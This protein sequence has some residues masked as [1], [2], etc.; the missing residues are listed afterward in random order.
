M[1]R[2]S[3]GGPTSTPL[4]PLYYTRVYGRAR[5]SPP[6]ERRHQG[7][8]SVTIGPIDWWINDGV[9]VPTRQFNFRDLDTR[10]K[11]GLLMCVA[12]LTLVVGNPKFLGCLFL[13][14]VGAA[15][16]ARMSE[17][18]WITLLVLLLL[19]TWGLVW[20]QGLFYGSLPRTVV[21]QIL[22]PDLWPF[23]GRE[24]LV[25]YR[26]GLIHGLVQSLRLAVATVFGAAVGGSTSPDQLLRALVHLRVPAGLA[27]LAA[28]ATR[29]LPFLLLSLHH[30]RQVATLRGYR[31]TWRRP[32]TRVGVELE[33]LRPMLASSVRRASDVAAA[34][35]VRAFDPG[36]EPPAFYRRSLTGREWALISG[37]VVLTS[38][39]LGGQL[40]FILYLQGIYYS[41]SLRPLY[42]LMRLLS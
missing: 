7:P 39:A 10:V 35:A 36:G 31:P 32:W 29:Q 4:L 42:Q 3:P 21:V 8:S 16:S 1:S 19:T 38:S 27:F 6:E 34:L 26:E 9:K 33:A 23:S 20:S 25:L 41:A 22:H 30:S 28:S 5:L 18:I 13:L 17:R 15:L 12:T 37:A 24:G 14:A 40:L 2:T 11:L